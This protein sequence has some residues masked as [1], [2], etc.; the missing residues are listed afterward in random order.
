MTVQLTFRARLA[1]IAFAVVRDGA[2]AV[3]EIPT[4]G[5]PR[6]RLATTHGNHRQE[7]GRSTAIGALPIKPFAC[8]SARVEGDP[9]T[10]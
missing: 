4:V 8:N 2:T 9:R 10:V 5:G 7:L 6:H 1:L 3:E